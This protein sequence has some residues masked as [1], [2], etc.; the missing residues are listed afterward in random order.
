MKKIG[1]GVLGL[2]VG[3]QLAR[4]FHA[5]DHCEL[6]WVNDLDR[7]KS[8]RLSRELEAKEAENLEQILNDSRVD[9]VAVATYDDVHVDQ[10]VPSL[11]SGRHVFSE[12]PL[13]VNRKQLLAIKKAWEE[14]G[15]NAKLFSNLILRTAPIYRWLREAIQKGEFGELFAADG[16]YLYGRLHKIIDGWRGQ[17]KD[18]SPMLGGGIHLIDLL[19]WFTEERPHSLFASGNNIATKSYD[20]GVEDFVVSTI[21]FDSGLIARVSS[22]L[23]CV[24]THQHVL[25]LFGTEKTFIL[26]DCGPRIHETRNPDQ[27]PNFLNLPFL[28]KNKGDL[29]PD[30]VDDILN[31]RDTDH[32]TQGVFDAM[33]IGLAV[34]QSFKSGSKVEIEY[35]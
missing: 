21:E 17:R 19:L 18:Y 33:S 20:L 6:L 1:V 3:E 13:C 7:A 26:D 23:A 9:L 16:D 14:Q 8:R 12:K 25:R 28:P 11:E 35:V 32:L 31:Q 34:N 2:G 4:T 24:H 30:F 27:E 15:G 22:N 5:H 10:V 29:I